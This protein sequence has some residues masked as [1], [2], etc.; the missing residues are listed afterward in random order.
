MDEK[1]LAAELAKISKSA[2]RLAWELKEISNL[3]KA[4]G[5]YAI[6]ELSSLANNRSAQDVP[7]I[8]DIGSR[9]EELLDSIS[10]LGTHEFGAGAL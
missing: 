7:R 8:A 9:T 1:D 2:A 5:A 4:R 10:R 6:G 3:A